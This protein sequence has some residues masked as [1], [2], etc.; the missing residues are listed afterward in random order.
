MGE[1]KSIVMN[2]VYYEEWFAIPK[3]F[4]VQENLHKKAVH[5]NTLSSQ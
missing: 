4:Q 2:S 3:V 5:K 1:K